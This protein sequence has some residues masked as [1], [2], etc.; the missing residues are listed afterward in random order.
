MSPLHGFGP[1]EAFVI[2][3]LVHEQSSVERDEIVGYFVLAPGG[4]D[5]GF[6]PDAINNKPC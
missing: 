2:G 6:P 4:Y 5:H 1:E 3:V